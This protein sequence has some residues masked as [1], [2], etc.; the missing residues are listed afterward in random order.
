[1]PKY[2]S[3][4][5]KSIRNLHDLKQQ[6]LAHKQI[7]VEGNL[8]LLFSLPSLLKRN[9]SNIRN[10]ILNFSNLCY[11]TL[12]SERMLLVLGLVTRSSLR[13]EPQKAVTSACNMVFW[14]I[15]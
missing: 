10:R 5:P 12:L 11:L 9:S 13:D 8:G 3:L 6:P 15:I 2:L 1:M 4:A 14:F 7:H